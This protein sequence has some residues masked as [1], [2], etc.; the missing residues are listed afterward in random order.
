M[1]KMMTFLGIAMMAVL[2]MVAQYKVKGAVSDADGEPVPYATIRVFAAV[3]SVKPQAVG[4]ADENGSFELELGSAG[5]YCAK[6]ASA[7]HSEASR[8]FVVS[9]QSPVADLATITLSPMSA[10][11]GEV[12]V[13]AQRPLV[14]KEIDRIGYDV[15]ADE[16]SR[17]ATVQDILRKVPL[18]TVDSDGTIKVSGTTDFK[19]YRNGR[20]NNSFTKN[21]KDVFAAIPASMIKKIEVITDPGAKEDAEGVGAIL[22]IIT[23]ENTSVKGVMGSASLD[24]NTKS[25]FV[26]NPNLYVMT[27]ID[28]V[29]L[30][31]YGGCYRMCRRNSLR[32]NTSDYTFESD[33]NRLV[34]QR[35]SYNPGISTW[36]GLDGS[37]EIDS[38]NLLTLELSSN[39]YD[40]DWHEDAQRT[41]T[42]ADGSEIYRYD[43]HTYYPK[44]GYRDGGIGIN[45]QHS[46][47]LK[48]ETLTASYMFSGS[49]ERVK[50]TETYD[51]AV[52]LP[53][54]YSGI[55]H[56]NRTDFAEHTLQFDWSRPLGA[57]QKLD[58]GGKCI[59]RRNHART[60]T[61]Y[62]GVEADYTDF[63]HQTHVAA[64]F[65][66]YRIK[67]GRFALRGGLRYEYS[68][69]SGDY[70]SDE[71]PDFGTHLN[72]WV[73]NAAVSYTADDH[74]SFKFSF[75]RRINRPGVSY[76]SPAVKK[77]PTSVSEGNPE[78]ES[79]RYNELNFNYGLTMPKVNIDFT[80]DYRFCDDGIISVQ[81]AVDNVLYST[82][83]NAGRTKGFRLSLY[84]QWTITEKTKFMFNGSANYSHYANRDA[85]PGVTLK[86]YG[87][88]GSFYTKITQRL[89][90]KLR[91]SASLNYWSGSVSSVYSDGHSVG[92]GA[93]D[94]S[95][96]LE[97]SFLKDD[98]LTITAIVSN[99]FGPYSW[100]Y[101][102]R[103]RNNAMI[104]EQ[105]SHSPYNCSFMVRAA[106]RF[107]T[108][109]AQVKKTS[110]SIS[111]DDV[112]GGKSIGN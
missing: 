1:K 16:D 68:H 57:S 112:V 107:G 99:P 79:A 48:G 38:M 5:D 30:S 87:W 44:Y 103:S 6:V 34:A 95:F 37:W 89:P 56:D 55:E 10:E 36:M 4:A 45:Y 83:A 71:T 46:T 86:N 98:R 28:N 60:F 33:G 13:T 2:E 29:A 67:L 64:L 63:V 58:L 11:L 82:Y 85:L 7:G 31:A 43:S 74:N 15:Q 93:W 27:Q 94:H 76:L 65:A 111:N 17:T 47:H 9:G 25:E 59:Y 77:T 80:A 96:W 51:N 42:A 108:L 24:M 14:V 66:D 92:P 61:D 8:Q 81:Q 21:A 110:H 22:N 18:V 109:N 105:V 12:T 53:V 20:P 97:R 40:V 52:N 41:M 75:S 88:G 19:I 54:G 72:D 69:L 84:C 102:T 100:D 104:G 73:P 106:Y 62:I 39:G 32:Q 49:N 3:D 23:L 50:G 70:R 90:L 35:E 26:P 78:L 101:V 91:L